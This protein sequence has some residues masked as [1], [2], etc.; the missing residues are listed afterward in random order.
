MLIEMYKHVTQKHGGSFLRDLLSIK[1][2]ISD[3]RRGA[4]GSAGGRFESVVHVD[5]GG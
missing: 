2:N 5:L 4:V 1:S 3:V